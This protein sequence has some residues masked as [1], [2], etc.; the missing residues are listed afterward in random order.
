MKCEKCENKIVFKSPNLCK[1]HF[2]KYIEN[3]VHK[4][5]KENNLIQKDDKLVIAA[6]GG[7]D[8]LTVLHITH[9]IHKNIVVLAI[10][11]GIKDY[12]EHTLETLKEFCKERNL[13]L[14]I[15]SYQK[16]FGQT[17]DSYLSKNKIRP[18]TLCGTFRRYLMNKYAK[19]LGA[20]KLL[21]GHNLD[22]EAQAFMMNLFTSQLNLSARQGLETGIIKD[23][24]FI[25]RIK[26]LYFCSEKEIRAYTFLKGWDLKYDECPYV[27]ESFRFSIS[28]ELN[29]YEINHKGSKENL[30]KNFLKI[31][32]KLKEKS[33]DALK[34]LIECVKCGEPSSTQVC[35]ACKFK[36]A[37]V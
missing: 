26:P 37:M 16:E 25:P 32:P 2:I 23:D 1:D 21:T 24:K 12:R 27:P 30:V 11:E 35:N 31:L 18:C 29:D 6:S 17:L 28:D 8:S 20:T 5:I 4:T 22:D 33:N 7:K 15:Y 13:E 3:K 9:L 10:D 34:P 36:K 19:K 14:H